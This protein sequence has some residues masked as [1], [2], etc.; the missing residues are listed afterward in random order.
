ML[1]QTSSQVSFS[2]YDDTSNKTRIETILLDIM[3]TRILKL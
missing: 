3:K 2:G 1:R